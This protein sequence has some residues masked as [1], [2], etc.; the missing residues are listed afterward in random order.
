LTPLDPVGTDLNGQIA[1]AVVVTVVTSTIPAIEAK[2]V[3]VGLR[4][5]TPLMLVVYSLSIIVEIIKV[6]PCGLIYREYMFI[7]VRNQH[8]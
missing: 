5:F 6:V 3:F 1:I 4:V 8:I 2:N 7:F